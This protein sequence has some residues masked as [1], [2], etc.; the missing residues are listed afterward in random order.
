VLLLAADRLK[1]SSDSLSAIAQSLGYDSRVPSEGLPT[2][3]GL[4]S[5]AV[6]EVYH[7]T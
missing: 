6:H 5:K 7:A 4:L 2:R 3:Y 1:S